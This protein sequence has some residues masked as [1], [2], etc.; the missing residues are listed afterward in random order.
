MDEGDASGVK[1]YFDELGE[2]EWD[3][4]E[5][6]L[7]SRVSLEMHRRFLRRWVLPGKRV[8]E[9]GAGP[10][11]FT[12]ELAR[13]GCRVVASDISGVQLDLNKRHVADASLSD[14]VESWRCLDVRDMSELATWSFDAV[15]AY[16]GPLSYVFED[17]PRALAECL[18]VVAPGG[19]VVASV[20]SLPGSARFFL[21]S[22]PPTIRAVGLET[23]ERFLNVGDQR[24]IEAAGAHACQ[25][26]SWADVQDIA[27]G[28]G[29][30]VLGATASN[31]LS[32]G[33][34]A[35]LEMLAAE[36]TWWEHFLDWE[37]S[38]SS[39]AGAIDGGTH[40]LFAVCRRDRRRQQV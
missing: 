5:I 2:K 22:F 33:S 13:L 29:A 23:F 39:Q 31:W 34:A 6:D 18:R 1:R 21:E 28:V 11:R 17:V 38:L 26:F 25:M 20:M 35:A 9:V 30:E 7:R 19:P 4:L 16:G 40:L 10:G 24:M 15:V 32:L 37:E 27:R 36:A 14:Q 3:R 12:I 8:L